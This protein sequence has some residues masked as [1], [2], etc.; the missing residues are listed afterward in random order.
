[1]PRVSKATEYNWKKLNSDTQEKLTKRANKTLSSKRITAISYLDD[2]RANRLLKN[3][4]PVDASVES[5]MY[6][7][8]CAALSQ[9]G[10][11]QKPHVQDFLRKYS[12]LG[13]VSMDIPEDT[14]DSDNDILGFIYQSLITEGERNKTGLYYTCRRVVEYMV[15]DKVLS[16]SETFLDPCCGSGAFLLAV[17]TNNPANLY[18][19]DIDSI[20]V[21]IASV[22]LLLKYHDKVF[23]PHIYCLDFLNNGLSSSGN[24]YG[25]P[26]QFD[27]VYTNPPWGSDKEGLYS[28]KYP[29]IKSKE[30]ASMIIAKSLSILS[31]TGTLYFLLPTSLLK[32]RAHSDIRKV[33]LSQTSIKQIDLYKG[34]FDGVFTDFFS[35]KLCSVTAS[36][37]KYVVNTEGGNVLISLS[38]K[39]RTAGHI[40]IESFSE[41]DMA[42][43]QKMESC[44]HDTLSHSSWALGIVTGDNKRHVQLSQADG[45]EPVYAGKQVYPFRLQDSPTYIRFKP[46]NFQQCAKE[47]Y[48]RAPEKLVYRFI[49]NYPIV[50]Y[51]DQQCL[52]L[53]SANI[54]IPQLDTISVKSVAAL[55]NSSLYHYYYSLKFSDIKV[56]KSYLQV[57]P[58]P[59]LTQQQDEGLSDLVTAIQSNS[60]SP[61]YRE[62]LDKTVFAIFGITVNEQD[63]ILERMKGEAPKT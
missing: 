2:S 9:K 17:K 26:F 31:P 38:D 22:N 62:Q 16:D 40:A 10:L 15:G 50:A 56:L 6:T 36:T 32:I 29:L 35:I 27:H 54:L 8:A 45:L 41:M 14:W 33:I 1:M 5:I 4:L 12:H 52:C 44:C 53:N 23:C 34:R 28:H 51:D 25:L 63:Y 55:L 48:Y 59:K 13:L 57:L 3:V 21:L 18:G 20:A 61:V 47:S 11:L 43:M 49:A 37:Q 42:I 58:F 30:R 39:D 7:L 24:R 19:F 46:E 60:Y